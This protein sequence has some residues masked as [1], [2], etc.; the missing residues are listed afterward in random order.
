MTPFLLKA[1]R[2]GEHMA[3]SQLNIIIRIF[4]VEPWVSVDLV[5]GGW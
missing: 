2:P 3:L 4:V 5:G 1:E